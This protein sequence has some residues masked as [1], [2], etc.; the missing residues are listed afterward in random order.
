MLMSNSP[1]LSSLDIA[2]ATVIEY[3]QALAVS[4]ELRRIHLNGTGAIAQLEAKL[5]AHY[6]KKY[7]LSCSNATTALLAIALALDLKDTA[8]ITTPLTYGATLAGFLLRGN[9]PQFV[10]L[11]PLTQTLCPEAVRLAI[12]PDTK[13]ILAVDIFGNPSDAVALKRI[14]DEAGLWY[15]SDASQSFGGTRAGLPA[16]ASADAIVVSF[17]AGK[18]LF[19]GEGG[20]VVTDNEE[21]YQKLVW[22]TQHPDRQ[23]RDLGFGMENQYGINS[24]INPLAAVIA[25]AT[26]ES[27][28]AELQVHQAD[29]MAVVDALNEIGLTVP[30][31]FRSQGILPTFFALVAQWQGTAEPERLIV[32]LD[33][34]GIRMKI[35]TLPCSWIPTQG[36]FIAQYEHLGD[37]Q[38]EPI[39]WVEGGYFTLVNR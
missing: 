17:T 26:F 16:S 6:G 8:F 27:S 33:N 19:C 1:R 22:H 25:N 11:D 23:R 31:P 13:A 24:R 30:M 5:A 14:A 20:A 18:T 28:L 7:A 39:E 4:P 12:A 15:I 36:A 2:Q 34:R 21:L 9:R 10:G 35:S 29:R 37:F 3:Y 38:P 32:A